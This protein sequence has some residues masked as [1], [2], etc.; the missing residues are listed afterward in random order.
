MVHTSTNGFA[1][2]MILQ[3]SLLFG[4][5]LRSSFRS[6]ASFLPAPGRSH[7]GDGRGLDHAIWQDGDGDGPWLRG[8][9]GYG[10]RIVIAS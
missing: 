8:I 1:C 2:F 3:V 4:T 9:Y 10:S 5:N 6:F 7:N